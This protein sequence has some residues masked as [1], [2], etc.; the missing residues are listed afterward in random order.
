MWDP[1]E[2]TISIDLFF[3]L[4]GV[5][6]FFVFSPFIFQIMGLLGSRGILPIN[7]YLKAIKRVYGRKAYRLVPSLFWINSSDIALLSVIW[8]GTGASILLI[9]GI[10]P[11]L[12]I[13]IL[14]LLHLSIVSTGQDFLSFGWE[15]FLLEIA[16]NSFFLSLTAAPNLMIW[17]SLNLLLFRFHFQAGAV[18]LQSKDPHWRNL[19]ALAYHYQTQPLPNT[20]AWFAHK[21]PLTIHKISTSMVFFIELIVSFG[22]FGPDWLRLVTFI[23]LAGLQLVIWATGNLSYLNHLTFVFAIILID[24]NIFNRFLDTPILTAASLNTIDILL[25]IIGAFLITLQAL[26]LWE[27]ISLTS[28]PLIRKFEKFLAPFHIV[29]RYGIFAVMTTKRFEIIIEGSVDGIEWKEYIF[30]NKPSKI[31][32]RPRR[33]SPIQ[34]RLD[35]QMW[36]LPFN[37]YRDNIWLQN[38]LTLL[39]KGNEEVRGLLRECPFKDIPPTYIRAVAYDY[40]FTD[41]KTKKLTGEWW[42]RTYIGLYSPTLKLHP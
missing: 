31:N 8:G 10:Y 1:S 28:H 38:F 41:W 19:T 20:L 9:M 13:L 26:N 27:N 42:K 23:F 6:Y 21:L 37:N 34:P 7:D 35:W 40:E 32:E 18:K 14:Y 24:N 17:I 5:I 12:M 3:R 16:C 36:F 22:I 2:Y 33:I 25:N 15:L 30:K 29:N 11:P 39:L 4:L